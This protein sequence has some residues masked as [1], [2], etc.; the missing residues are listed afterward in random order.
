MPR[1]SPRSRKKPDRSARVPGPG[2]PRSK[3]GQSRS[4]V[5][6]N[7]R[8][9][10]NGRA[11]ARPEHRAGSR[12]PAGARGSAEKRAGRAIRPGVRASASGTPRTRRPVAR[13]TAPRRGRFK[14]P[15]SERVA[16]IL[17]ILERLYPDASTALDHRSPLQLLI[18]TILSAQC[19]DERVNRVTPGLFERYPDAQSLASAEGEELEALIRST[20]FYRNKARA[21]Q[22]CCA[23]LVV[24]HRGQVPKTLEELTALK[25]VGRK[26]A[27]VVLGNSFGIPGLVVDT[28]VGRLSR[29]LGLTREVDPVKVEFALMEIVPREKW[30]RFSHWLILHGRRTCIARKPRCSV[31]PLLPH[32]PRAG[33]TTAQ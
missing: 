24:K 30:T 17:A 27:N 26:T 23:D 5:R 12:L 32:C 18:A 6:A 19:T 10:A 9:A 31:C 1:K 28:H 20:G 8:G 29:R 33:V 22:S 13:A 21:I 11:G 3:P 25:G 2:R 7:A 16:A 4:A 14:P 15:D